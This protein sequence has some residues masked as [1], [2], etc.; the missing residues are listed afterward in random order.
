MATP[1]QLVECVATALDVPQATVVLYDRVLAENG[2]R[3]KG[4]RGK[5]AGR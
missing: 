1:G 5:S 3:S 2:L 4:G